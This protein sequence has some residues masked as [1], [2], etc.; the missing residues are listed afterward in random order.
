MYHDTYD[1]IRNGDLYGL[2][3][4]F[5]NA[6]RVVWQFVSD[7]KGRTMVTVVTMRTDYIPHTL[8]WLHGLNP[9]RIYENEATGQRCSGALLMNAGLTLAYTANN[10]DDI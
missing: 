2:I 8:V 1:P 3:F 6:F 5:E 4:P 10:G 7:D 9:D